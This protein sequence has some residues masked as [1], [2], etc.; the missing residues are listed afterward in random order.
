MQRAGLLSAA[1]TAAQSRALEAAKQPSPTRQAPRAGE[2]VLSNEFLSWRLEWRDGRLASTE[3][4]NRISGRSFPLSS[5]Q[6]FVLTLSASKHRVEIPWWRFVFGPDEAPVPPEEEQGFRLGYHRPDFSEQEWGA[7]EN[8]LLRSLQGVK[9]VRGGTTYDGYGW[10]RRWFELPEIARDEELVFVLGGYDHLDWKQY[11]VYVNGLEIGR[12]ESS[13]RWRTPAQFSIAPGTAAHSALRFGSGEKNLLA[14]RAR[15][16][17][18][19]FGGLSDEVLKHYVFEPVLV[20]QFISVG[21]PYLRVEDFEVLELEQSGKDQVNFGLRSVSQPIQVSVRYEL[22]GRARRKR[23]AIANT[24]SKDALLLDLQI[25]DFTTGFRAT[26][27]G[28]GEPIFVGDEVFAAIEHPA[29]LNQGDGGHIR[30]THFPGRPLP[31]GKTFE[32]HTA[33]LGV[34]EPGKALE[35]FISYIEARSPRKKK[36]TSLYTPYGINNQWGGCPPLADVEVLDT[37]GV[38]E[39][40]QP[41]GVKFD[42]FTLDQGWADPTSDLKRFAPQCFPNGPGEISERVRALGMKLGLWFAVSWGGWSCGEYPAVW[43]SQI[44]AP[45]HP[46]EPAA[47]PL[48]YRNGYIADGGVPGQLCV[49]SDPYFNILKDA[50]LYHIKQNHLKFFK[51]DIGN[52]YCNS[53]RHNHLPGK[54]SVEAMYE[55]L[56]E[57]AAAARAAEP[58][59]YVMWYWGVRS[60]FFALH[61]DSIFESGLFMEGS[62]TSWYPTLYYRDSVTLNLDQSTQFAKTI[63]PLNKDSL[64]IWLADTR[65][66][67]FM[68][69][70][71]WREALVMDLGRGSLLFPQLWGDANLLGE[72]DLEFLAEMIA[73]VKKNEFLLL[74][75]RKTL[76]DPWKNDVYGYAYGDGSRAF[77]FLNNVHFVSRRVDFRAGPEVGLESASGSTL[78]VVSHFPE[79]KR[80]ARE[81][82]SEFRA[83][84]AVQLWARPFEVLLLEVNPN[85]H[86]PALPARKVFAKEAAELG[87]EVPLEPLPRA[88][89]MDLRFADADRFEKQGFN[90]TISAWSGTLPLLDGEQ[91]ILAIAVRLR[92][93]KAEWRYSPVVAEI[94]QVLARIGDQKIQLIPVPDA[95]QFGNTQKAGCSWVVYKVRLNRRWSGQPL[96]FAVHAYLP[97][98]V[99][100]QVQAWVVKQWWEENA[101]PLGDGFYGDEPS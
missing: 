17:D 98:N 20:D 31:P 101:R 91:P 14:V 76:G 58:E 42:Y 93:G 33:L 63:P 15:G 86:R 32:T 95:R 47:P 38:L 73:F 13:G 30:L 21:E 68:G 55:R 57:I 92:E 12:D 59:V 82:G 66:G 44:P 88:D 89:W 9:R 43:P 28:W 85:S 24:G 11:W 71:R 35:E 84:D 70:Q 34:T 83:G 97:A 3:F 64:G 27:G 78:Q 49:A 50:V 81:D 87:R 39:K 23:L 2:V 40:W 61:G 74:R 45:G 96:R 46:D 51:L 10:F 67:N 16:Y 75:P 48:A 26:E 62:G 79:H 22:S 8:L 18:K 100:T 72:R 5:V 65:W 69:N 25:D 1:V 37:L 77:V 29:G 19:H 90:K 52:Y 99:D 53:T 41:R 94:V 56:L 36:A 54:Y 60:P 80:I 6:E 4:E 7:T